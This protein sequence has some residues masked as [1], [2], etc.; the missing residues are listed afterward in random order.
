MLVYNELSQLIGVTIDTGAR[1]A[2]QQT[3][4]SYDPNLYHKWHARCL[5]LYS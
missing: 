2:T 5:P 1:K 4:L 3:V